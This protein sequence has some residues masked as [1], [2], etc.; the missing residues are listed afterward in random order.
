LSTH[1]PFASSAL[2][3]I[4]LRLIEPSGQ[5]ET[6]RMGEDLSW[7]LLVIA[8]LFPLAVYLLMLGMVN[9]RQAPLIVPGTWDFGGVLFGASGFILAGG[10]FVLQKLAKFLYE[11]NILPFGTGGV[12]ILWLL[13][14][15][16]LLATVLGVGYVLLRRRTCTTIYN[17]SPRIFE[18]ALAR[19][20]EVKG[21]FWSRT[22][23]QWIIQTKNRVPALNPHRTAIMPESMLPVPLPPAVPGPPEVACLNIHSFELGHTVRLQWDCLSER[24]EQAIRQE[25]ERELDTE[26]SELVTANNY[27]ALWLVGPAFLMLVIVFICLVLHLIEELSLR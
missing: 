4:L 21:L 13:L 24:A 2:T 11:A 10:W 15:I 18:R 12:F 9:R 27:V 19:I 1:F 20:L 5:G 16:Y 8:F 23:D 26:L 7:Y 6:V 25:V 3:I 17:I 22:G 14:G